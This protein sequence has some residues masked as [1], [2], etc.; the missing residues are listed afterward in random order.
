MKNIQLIAFLFNSGVALCGN[1]FLHAQTKA[2]PVSMDVVPSAKITLPFMEARTAWRFEPQLQYNYGVLVTAPKYFGFKAGNLSAGGSLSKLNSPELSQTVSWSVAQV[3]PVQLQASLPQTKTFSKPDS[4]FVQANIGDKKGTFKQASLNAFWNGQSLTASSDLQVSLGQ[5][6]NLELCITGGVYPYRQSSQSS[7][8]ST[9]PPYHA[10]SHF[11][12]GTQ[13]GILGKPAGALFIINTYESPWGKLLFTW[14]GETY[15]KFQHFAFNVAGF[16]NTNDKVITTSDKELSPLGQI[17]AS[18][19]YHFAAGNKHPVLVKTGVGA[20]A[21]INLAEQEHTLKTNGGFRI[22]GE[23]L[24]V[25]GGTKMNFGMKSGGSDLGVD[26]TGGSMNAG[27]SGFI[28]QFKPELGTK[29][30]F[31]PDSK[32]NKWTFTEKLSLKCGWN[33]KS[34]VVQLGADADITF[35][36]KN[37]VNKTDYSFGADVQIRLKWFCLK[38]EVDVEM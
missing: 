34:G 15:F 2:L 26:F 16:L 33:D 12:A 10:G 6:A 37:S 36:Q 18:A 1:C 23:K 8:F 3:K 21:D 31:T 7:W 9:S 32:K 19:Q 25:Y 38:V 14:R 4:L 17:R 11:C 24:N 29:F 35:T 30:S 20:Q 13:L 27:V 5:A 28:R 22:T